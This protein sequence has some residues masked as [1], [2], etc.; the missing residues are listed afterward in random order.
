VGPCRK[1]AKCSVLANYVKEH[2][3]EV[4][5]PASWLDESD[6]ISGGWHVKVMGLPEELEKIPGDFPPVER[7]IMTIQ[8]LE[9]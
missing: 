9:H 3:I 8:P 7:S 5:I 1:R 2:N 4:R 6:L